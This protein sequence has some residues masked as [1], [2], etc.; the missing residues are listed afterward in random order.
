MA[1]CFIP[2]RDRY[3]NE[4]EPLLFVHPSRVLADSERQTAALRRHCC[5][6]V[7]LISHSLVHGTTDSLRQLLRQQLQ[8]QQQQQTTQ[9]PHTTDLHHLNHPPFPVVPLGASGSMALQ[10]MPLRSMTP[11]THFAI[12]YRQQLRLSPTQQQIGWVHPAIP[13]NNGSD[14]SSSLKNLMKQTSQESYGQPGEDI[15]DKYCD[16]LEHHLFEE[17]RENLLLFERYSRYRYENVW[18]YSTSFPQ[19]GQSRSCWFELEGIAD[20]QPAVQVGDILLLRPCEMVRKKTYNRHHHHNHHPEQHYPFPHQFPPPLPHQGPSVG[21]MEIQV[22]VSVVTRSGPRNKVD[23]IHA[24]WPEDQRMQQIAIEYDLP[25]SLMM[26]AT[27]EPSRNQVLSGYYNIRLVPN[28]RPLIRCLTAVD[29]LRSTLQS[30]TVVNS[31]SSQQK[32]P[33]QTQPP[34]P[35]QQQLQ[36]QQSHLLQELLF[37]T[38]APVLPSIKDDEVILPDSAD[39]NKLNSKQLSFVRVLLQRTLHPSTD[40]VRGPLIL[41]GPAGTCSLRILT[42]IS[43]SYFILTDALMLLPIDD[44]IRHW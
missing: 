12:K 40:H 23:R 35:Q 7:P 41:T 24:T 44:V 39:K 32:P 4:Q 2:Q 1:D 3:F 38:Q 11:D 25:K 20:A 16:A 27:A 17:R 8:H 34:P 5:F 31:A 13:L 33:P 26:M 22:Q 36:Q 29:W 28:P 30:S 43:S 6:S 19:E 21:P 42:L 18:V 15:M 14:P 10:G 37:P 9:T